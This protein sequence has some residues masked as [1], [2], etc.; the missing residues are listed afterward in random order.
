MWL[1]EKALVFVDTRSAAV[2][3]Y[4]D[5]F[6][7]PRLLRFAFERFGSHSTQL[8][9]FSSVLADSAAAV[10]RLVRELRAPTRS[11]TVLLPLGAAFP[12][13]I[14]LAGLRKAREAEVEEVDAVRFRLAT[15]LPF[16]VAQ[17]EVRTESS[18]S[19]GAGVLLAQAIPRTLIQESEKAMLS[20]GFEKPRVASTLSAALRGLSPCPG[21]V[22]LILGDSA[23][24]I[25]VRNDLGVVEAVHLRLL[26][27][28]EDRARR[29]LDEAVR[30][31][32][33][34]REI[35][36]LGEDV[37]NLRSRAREVTIL[38]G[39]GPPLLGGSADP[40]QF[41]FLSVFHGKTS[42]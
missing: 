18:P 24:A 21:M 11:A 4:R 34:L 2:A 7:G 16:P 17:A 32:P 10:S 13:I 23:C 30:A 33:E 14:A 27:E 15:V 26:L 12:S 8:A 38:S 39:F 37:E 3:V 25:A 9:L 29:S 28:G 19:I 40:Q 5:G 41:P 31:T 6:W 36:A 22:D 20:L 35:R 1:S 42:R